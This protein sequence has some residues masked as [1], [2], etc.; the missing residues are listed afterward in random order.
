MGRSGLE[1][2]GQSQR[3]QLLLEPERARWAGEAAPPRVR[4]RVRWGRAGRVSAGS[5]GVA[6]GS[7]VWPRPA[8]AE[9]A[10]DCAEAAPVSSLLPPAARAG[11]GCGCPK[12]EAYSGG[13]SGNWQ[14]LSKLSSHSPGSLVWGL[15]KSVSRYKEQSSGCFSSNCSARLASGYLHTLA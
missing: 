1:E 15:Y 7:G 6:R 3:R 4:L 11:P 8:Q 12:C 5:A 13:T 14:E 10:G 9:G 2:L